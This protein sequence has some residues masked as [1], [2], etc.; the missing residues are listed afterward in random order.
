MV[1]DMLIENIKDPGKIRHILFA[2]EIERSRRY[3]IV[4]LREYLTLA[5]ISY[6][7]ASFTKNYTVT[8]AVQ[9][10]DEEYQR[11]IDLLKV[12]SDHILANSFD[13]LLERDTEGNPA[14]TE[15]LID[16][17]ER[18][19]RLPITGPVQRYLDEIQTHMK[20]I[21]SKGRE[22]LDER[23]YYFATLM[24]DKG[25]LLNA[26]V[27]LDEAIAAY[28]LEAL[29]RLDPRLRIA[30]ERFEER[31]VT[32]DAKQYN[33]YELNNS[34]KSLIKH[35]QKYNGDLFGEPAAK[36]I[37]LEATGK[38]AWKVKRV[39]SLI[40]DCDKL[41]N[42]LAHGNN[43]R[44]LERVRDDIAHLLRRYEEV[45]RFEDVLS[46]FST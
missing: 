26:V 39:R 7:L 28:A 33:R 43:D 40:F 35:L 29:R 18:I 17:L 45:C 38:I 4:D 36:S 46:R 31:I 1:V 24:F 21:L 13:Y 9:T 27:L 16:I 3:E 30:I 19:K 34:A 2:K 6:A 32:Q 23:Y 10:V 20:E 41:R 15:K 5:N 12:F 25:Y 14:L 42:D 44:R 37:A 22:P 8:T 11:L